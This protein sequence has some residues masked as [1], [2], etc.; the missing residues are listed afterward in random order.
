MRL[1]SHILALNGQLKSNEHQL[2]KLVKVSEAALLLQEVWFGPMTAPQ[3]VITWSHE[4]RIHT[5]AS[6]AALAGV[7]PIP[8]SS[9]NTVRHRLNRGGDRA[10]NRALHLVALNRM[11]YDPVTREYVEK[12]RTAG[13]TDRE[14][15]RCIKRHL[16]R[17]VYR[18][19]QYAISYEQA[20]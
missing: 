4:N 17:H 15:R 9:G 7:N 20:Y 8:A 18:T 11:T 2:A 3:C 1:A 14:I 6:F 12:R 16:S 10:L 13:K 19:L 5:E